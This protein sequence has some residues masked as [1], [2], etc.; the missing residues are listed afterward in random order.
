MHAE[1]CLN[2]L[3]N[4]PQE[5]K[6]EGAAEAS[7]NSQQQ[8]INSSSSIVDIR[9][10][11]MKYREDSPFV[12]KSVNFSLKENDKVAIIGRTGCGKTT[13]MQCITRLIEPT[14]GDIDYFG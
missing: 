12:L 2:M 9:N 13:L 3:E 10:L 5:A 14:L 7:F 1:R 8:G 6:E 11:S 4:I